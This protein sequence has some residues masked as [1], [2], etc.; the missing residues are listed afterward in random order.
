MTR[1]GRMWDVIRLGHEPRAAL[2]C[3][4]GFD[5]GFFESE[6]LQALFSLSLGLDRESGSTNSYLNATDSVLQRTP[7]GVFYDHLLGERANELA[8]DPWR[9]DVAPRAFHPKLTLL[10]YGDTIRVMISSANLSRAAWS[11]LLELFVFEELKPGEPH[12]WSAGLRRFCERLMGHVPERQQW[13]LAEIT[14]GLQRV[15]QT[16]DES[17]VRSSWDGRLIDALC[18]GIDVAKRLDAV[19]PF[20]EGADGEGVFDELRT[21]LGD[22]SGALFTGIRNSDGRPVVNG[23][24]AK[25]REL[26]DDGWTLQAVLETWEGDDADAPPRALHGKLLA[27][28]HAGGARIMVGSA[29]LTRAAL[30]HPATRHGN[31]ELVVVT[32]GRRADLRAM[33]PQAGEPLDLDDVEF[34]GGEDPTGEDAPPSKPGPETLVVEATYCADAERLELELKPE[35]NAL[36]V[37]YENRVLGKATAARWNAPLVLGTALHVVVSIG[38]DSGIVPFVIID[39]QSLV[40]RGSARAPGFDELCDVLAG[41]RQL[42]VQEDWESQSRTRDSPSIA[43]LNAPPIVGARGT[44]PWRRYLAAVAGLGDQLEYERRNARGTRV[45]I[46]NRMQLCGLRRSLEEAH[47]IG[48]FTRADL[49]YALYELA[50]RLRAVLSLED[51]EADSRALVMAEEASL[52][53]RIVSL[54]DEGSDRVG[55]QLA[56]L[57]S[58]DRE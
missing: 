16:A 31:V 23:P 51:M 7:V 13:K 18:D 11:N 53:D 17:P 21:R 43:S 2:F 34:D 5:P 58:A 46:E 32:D 22:L 14:G 48:R 20:F 52:A 3:T 33:L 42:S 40:P 27:V 54:A 55:A 10:D 56:I 35:A 37:R 26:T 49:A 4:Y 28:T 47:K 29:N 6:I 36:T 19:T 44:I 25:L 1:L 30:L 39:P 8:Y 15:P 57:E 38:V 9:V 41:Y 24:E 45:V 50:R 12:P